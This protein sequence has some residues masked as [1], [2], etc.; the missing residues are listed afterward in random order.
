M[1]G[2]EAPAPEAYSAWQS[3]VLWVDLE[4][5]IPSQPA[6][7]GSCKFYRFDFSGAGASISGRMS[8]DGCL[9]LRQRSFC[10]SG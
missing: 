8:V 6:V 2:A 10:S 5:S 7:S 1:Q 9:E 4:G 3:L